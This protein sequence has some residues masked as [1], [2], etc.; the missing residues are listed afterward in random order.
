M[1]ASVAL[2]THGNVNN[3]QQTQQQQLDEHCTTDA[4]TEG[5]SIALEMDT[6]DANEVASESIITISG[7]FADD[8]DEVSPCFVIKYA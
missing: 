3:G 5:L 7:S 4:S 8:S 6:H 2:P 1:A